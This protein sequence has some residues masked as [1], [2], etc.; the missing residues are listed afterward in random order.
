MTHSLAKKYLNFI[1]QPWK[2]YIKEN[3]GITHL[4]L[5]VQWMPWRCNC[6]AN[7]QDYQCTDS[8]KS[9]NWCKILAVPW[10]FLARLISSLECYKF[11]LSNHT[12]MESQSQETL[13]TIL[14]LVYE[15]YVYSLIRINIILIWSAGELVSFSCPWLYLSAQVIRTVC[16]I[17]FTH[18]NLLSGLNQWIWCMPKMS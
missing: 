4:F 6:W 7:R 8:I 15:V 13:V 17:T 10:N 12:W 3:M 9:Q 5:R 18:E 14:E 11:L 2:P 1:S 16:G